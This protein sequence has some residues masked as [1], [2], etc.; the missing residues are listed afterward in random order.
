MIGSHEKFPCASGRLSTLPFGSTFHP[1]PLRSVG[2]ADVAAA[3]GFKAVPAKGQADWG[4]AAA[5][6]SCAAALRLLLLLPR[7][8]AFAATCGLE[9]P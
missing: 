3:E 5:P 8:G 6:D 1:G 4:A 2:G 7:H 9:T